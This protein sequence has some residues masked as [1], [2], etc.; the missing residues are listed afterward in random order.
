MRAKTIATMELAK[1]TSEKLLNTMS[2]GS[3]GTTTANAV[4]VLNWHV[5]PQ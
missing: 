4:S 1:A 5:V 2:A 3:G